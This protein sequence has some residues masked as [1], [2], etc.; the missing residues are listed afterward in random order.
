MTFKLFLYYDLKSVYPDKISEL[1]Q[2]LD[3]IR[4]QHAIEFEEI[5]RDKMTS[6]SEGNLKN[7]L[8]KLQLHPEGRGEIVTGRGNMLPLSKG[9]N[10]NLANTPILLIE[11]NGKPV[12]VL[13]KRIQGHFTSV[14]AGLLDM[15]ENG[16]QIGKI[17]PSVENMAISRVIKD[18]RI[19]ED[20][21]EI[22]GREIDVPAGKIDLLAKDQNQMYLVVEF[23]REATDECIGQ[24]IRLSA[25]FVKQNKLSSEAVRKMIVCGRAYDHYIDAAKSV[26]IEV[27]VLPSILVLD[28]AAAESRFP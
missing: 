8:Y 10:L 27:R 28:I 11:E 4:T 22:I 16:L 20:G 23:E 7:A 5:P 26:S 2:L 13:P 18:P 17:V 19:I 25:S 9:K 6:E 15:L 12:D 24:I 3:S 14:K 1:V 21:L